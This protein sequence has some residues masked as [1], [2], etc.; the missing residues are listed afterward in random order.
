MRTE[1]AVSGRSQFSSRV[2][3]LCHGSYELQIEWYAE[4]FRTSGLV[5]RRQTLARGEYCVAS[6]TIVWITP[7]GIGGA[8]HINHLRSFREHRFRSCRVCGGDHVSQLESGRWVRI[9]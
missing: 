3:L 6:M 2:A 7:E 8:T 9:M 4:V 5:C 1:E